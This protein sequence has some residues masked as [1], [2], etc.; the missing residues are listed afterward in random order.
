MRRLTPAQR[1]VVTLYYWDDTPV[2]QIAATLSMPENT[3]K[4]HLSRARGALRESWLSMEGE[5]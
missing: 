3:V 4:T 1:A 2:D 5:R